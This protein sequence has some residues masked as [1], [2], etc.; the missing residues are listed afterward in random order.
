MDI[1]NLIEKYRETIEDEN[2]TENQIQEFLE[3][4]GLI[5]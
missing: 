3:Y 2:N 4:N 5:N 1:E